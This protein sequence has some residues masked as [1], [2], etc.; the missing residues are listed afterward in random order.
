M[1]TTLVVTSIHPPNAALRELACGSREHGWDFIVAGDSKSPPGFNIE[2]CR[3]L[4]LGDQRGA[5]FSLGLKCPE[6]SYTRKN[7]GYLEAMRAGAEVIVETDDDNHPR[8]EFWRA[9]EVRTQCRPVEREGWVNVYRYFS[10]NFIYPRG[11]PLNHARD[12]VPMAGTPGS[13]ECLIQQG[14]ADS[15]P[16]VDAV[17]RMLFPLP[18]H[19]EIAHDPVLL[20]GGSWCPFNS[21]NTTFFRDAFPL[22]YL[23]AHCSFR[24]TDIWRSFVAQRVLSEQGS[25]VM[26]H[27]PTVWQERNDHDLHRDFLDETPGYSHNANIRSDLTEL[28]FSADASVQT[29]M[30]CCYQALIRKEWVGREEEQLLQAWFQDL[31][32]IGIL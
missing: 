5:G 1:S 3:F 26:F 18:F 32:S 27:G 23:P 15:D 16:D 13:Y 19:F 9:R 17:Y 22:L 4:S 10:G 24:M 14:L 28:S 8:E 29:M 7:I 2:G 11:L 20:A 6:R 31:E 12:E 30:E 21:Q 25:G